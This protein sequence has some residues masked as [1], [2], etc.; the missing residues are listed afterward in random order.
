MVLDASLGEIASAVVVALA[1][2][3]AAAA[4]VVADDTADSPM[5]AGC[6]GCKQP[7]SV[8]VEQLPSLQPSSTMR[9]LEPALRRP[10]IRCAR[11]NTTDCTRYRMN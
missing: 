11:Y 3:A 2:T 9:M 4:V 1:E 7:G 8:G 6:F 10:L 5:I